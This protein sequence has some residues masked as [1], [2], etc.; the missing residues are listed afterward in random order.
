MDSEA[1]NNILTPYFTT[2]EAGKGSGL[3]LSTVYN[4]VDLHHGFIRV[5]SEINMGASFDV[6]LPISNKAVWE[7]SEGERTDP[8]MGSGTILVVDDE[9]IIQGAASEILKACGY[10]VV[11][12]NNGMEAINKFEKQ[13]NQ[14]RAVLLDM[15]IPEMSGRVAF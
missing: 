1:I 14:I 15:V 3:G 12:A 2:K 6:Y 13:F 4:V 8:V 7:K 10:D 9:K 11:T 5:E